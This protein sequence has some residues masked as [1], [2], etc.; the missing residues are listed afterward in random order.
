[1]SSNK[2]VDKFE[3]NL[4]PNSQINSAVSNKHFGYIQKD[5]NGINFQSNQ[6][7]DHDELNPEDYAL[8]TQNL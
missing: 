3:F 6:N 5:L 2:T 8:M 4:N 1:M 7:V